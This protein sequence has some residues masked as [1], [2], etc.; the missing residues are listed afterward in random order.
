MGEPAPGGRAPDGG[1]GPSILE[2]IA[3]RSGAEPRVLLHDD[4]H[5]PSPVLRVKPDDEEAVPDD[6]RYTVAGE[7]GE[8]GVGV[9]YKARD[10]DL[11]RDVAL[12]VLR[13]ALSARDDVVQRF[14]EEAQ[15]GGQLQHPGIVP[16]Y[17]L[18]LTPDGRPF[19]TMKLVRGETLAAALRARGSPREDLPRFLRLFERVC[20]TMA[21][22][23]A[24]GVLHRDLKPSNVLLGRFG[25]AYVLD[26]GF[27]KVLG[28]A[29][30]AAPESGHTIVTTVR[31]GSSG[32]ASLTGSVMGTPAYMPPEQALG[33][34]EDLTERADVFSLGAILA[35]ILTGKPPYVGEPKELLLMASQGRLEEARERL[36][37]CGAE[38]AL[39][40]LARRCLDPLPSNRPENAGAL[41][42]A[43]S[44]HFA[45]VRRRAEEAELA[46]V[47]ERARLLQ[48]TD[49]ARW[50]RRARRAQPAAGGA[51]AGAG[52]RIEAEGRGGDAGGDAAGRGRA[53]GGGLAGRGEGAAAGPRGG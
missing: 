52:G 5:E 38:P 13:G 21:Y 49:H 35:E 47:R 3:G 20:Q 51:G 46:A 17:G 25:E 37:A 19:F 30:P 18:G 16:V 32:S 31:T 36:A 11:G 39:T 4:P 22:A 45:D 28:R 41:V 6:S 7:I 48:A 53:P 29:E 26:W 33:R 40:D 2:R 15:I 50:E 44:A 12:K 8:G 34:V 14:V 23:H 42:A 1:P 24:R 43:L 9:V 27:G 10:R